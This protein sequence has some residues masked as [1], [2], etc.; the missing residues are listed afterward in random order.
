LTR[1][2]R[3]VNVFSLDLTPFSQLAKPILDLK[4]MKKLAAQLPETIPL[5]SDAEDIVRVITTIHGVDNSVCDS[6]WHIQSPF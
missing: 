4:K 2:T 6:L 1:P 3:R 5:A